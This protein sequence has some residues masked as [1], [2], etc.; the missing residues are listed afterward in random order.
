MKKWKLY[1]KHWY[2][3]L[4]IKDQTVHAN[5]SVADKLNSLS[6]NIGAQEQETPKEDGAAGHWE[7]L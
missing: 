4:W 2:V 5:F 6:R 7:V 3:I 1:L